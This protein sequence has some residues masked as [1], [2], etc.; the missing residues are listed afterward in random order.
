MTLSLAGKPS[1]PRTPPSDVTTLTDMIAAPYAL[2]PHPTY[3]HLLHNLRYRILHTR[4]IRTSHVHRPQS[5]RYQEA[6]LQRYPPFKF[7]ATIRAAFGLRGEPHLQQCVKWTRS[8]CTRE[9]RYPT[10]LRC[11]ALCAAPV[12]SYSKSLSNVLWPIS[13]TAPSVPLSN[14]GHAVQ[15]MGQVE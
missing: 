13:C 11:S 4:P 10:A 14:S 12:A 1:H 2:Q 8:T 15:V 3:S 6:T 9:L 7:H 5:L